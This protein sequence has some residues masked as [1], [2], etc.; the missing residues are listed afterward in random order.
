MGSSQMAAIDSSR[1]R[2]SRRS[3]ERRAVGARGVPARSA[4]PIQ[5]PMGET[6]AEACS[7]TEKD[8]ERSSSPFSLTTT[9]AS[10]KL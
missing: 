3:R 6:L 5:K 8:F 2:R 10:I 4:V 7:T 9:G 1:F